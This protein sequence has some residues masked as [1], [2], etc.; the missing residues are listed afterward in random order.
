[1]TI[2]STTVTTAATQVQAGEQHVVPLE[3]CTYRVADQNLRGLVEALERLNKR[4]TRLSVPLIRYTV[5]D[6]VAVPTMKDKEGNVTAWRQVHPVTLFPERIKLKGWSL[7]AVLESVSDEVM[8]RCV[9]GVVVAPKARSL[10][11]SYCDH[12]RTSRKRTET[13]LL[14]HDTGATKQ[15]GRQCLKDFLGHQDAG[16]MAAYAEMVFEAMA[17]GDDADDSRS[18]GSARQYAAV[19]RFLQ[20]VAAVIRLDGWVSSSAA[21][22][23]GKASTASV[24]QAAYWAKASAMQRHYAPTDEDVAT[25]A[26]A[27]AWVAEAF[28]GKPVEQRSDYEHNAWLSV[29][30]EVL[31]DK[32]AGLAA[33]VVAA[34]LRHQ[35]SLRLQA[36]AGRVKPVDAW[37]ATVGERVSFYA[38]LL[39]SKRIDGLYGTTTIHRML[40]RDGVTVVWF[41]SGDGLGSVEDDGER[42]FTA[43][44]KRHDE[45]RGAKQTTVSRLVEARDEAR[46]TLEAKLAKPARQKKPRATATRKLSSQDQRLAG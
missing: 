23:G 25:A 16:S 21:K 2:A 8:V 32:H 29:R 22:A 7:A 5:G 33:S 40:T 43:T 3:P 1:M 24:A 37:L 46:T 19:G 9:P 14:H 44:I 42:L 38:T 35:D 26:A 36:L 11:P 45:F 10:D 27:H 20:L 6:V 13:F 4:A 30:G 31:G 41:A 15:V 17:L 39:T 34:W 18:T 12:C 28:G